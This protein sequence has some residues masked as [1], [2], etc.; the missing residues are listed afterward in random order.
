MADIAAFSAAM[1]TQ[2][3]GPIREQVYTNK[4]LLW[5]KR[6]RDVDDSQ[7]MPQGSRDF[8]GIQVDA[9][10]ID[11]I[12][13]EF[14]IPLHT[15]RN[16]GSG[17]R[18]ENAKLPK[19]GKQAYKYITGDLQYMYGLFSV[20][21]PLLKASESNKGAFAKAL[22]QEMERL[23]DDVKGHM[24]IAAYGDGTGVIAVLTDVASAPTYEVDS[25]IWITG[26]EWCDLYDTALS[27][28]RGTASREITA[29]SRSAKTVTFGATFSGAQVGDKLI[30]A[31]EDSTS[32]APNN[33]LN[34]AI[35]GL[36]KIVDS[37][38]ALHGLNPGTA[39]ESFWASYEKDVAGATVGDSQLRELTDG[40]GTESGADDDLILITTRGIR[41]RYA[42]Q[43][44]ALKRFTDDKSVTLRGGFKAILFDDK[45]MV[46]DD[47]CQIGTVYGL[48]ID[49]LFWTQMSDFEWMEEDG[50]VLKWVSGYDQYQGV[51]FKYANL[52]TYARN[53][54]GKLTGAADD[55]K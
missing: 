9:T 47:Q 10:G 36:A 5:G 34:Q 26:G 43:L 28:Y 52:G 33:D 29:F 7:P 46:Y 31:S 51:L 4:I 20:T 3:L 23:V 55:D 54:H 39:G 48:N 27:S 19:A 50:T 2:F 14:R 53:R 35:D 17:F 8:R 38:G 41:S 40:I 42:D 37:A 30:R 22:S 21:G 15:G 6:T 32:S 25:T 13:N 11:F 44:T 49:A 18:A 16:R 12:G 45:A 24:N 1:K